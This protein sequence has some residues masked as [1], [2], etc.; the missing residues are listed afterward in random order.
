MLDAHLD[1]GCNAKCVFFAMVFTHKSTE[2][3]QE[4]LDDF[5]VAAP[6]AQQQQSSVAS[7]NV[8][9]INNSR[10]LAPRLYQTNTYYS[11]KQVTIM[12]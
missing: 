9:L 7:I 10:K 5:A 6:A 2:F 12:R 11:H 4:E 1:V 8:V 3:S